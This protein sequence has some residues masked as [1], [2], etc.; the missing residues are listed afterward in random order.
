[1]AEQVQI[2]GVVRKVFFSSDDFC[3]GV[4]V[5]HESFREI[6]FRGPCPVK[7][8]E[9]VILRG[10]WVDDP[11]FGRQLAADEFEMDMAMDPAALQQW[12]RVS[13]SAAGIGESRARKI[14]QRFGS[15]FEKVLTTAPERFT[16]ECGV[17]AA[18]VEALRDEW[19]Q[20]GAT[21]RAVIALG[22][23]GVKPGRAAR[24]V[25]AHGV[26]VVSI[27]RE[28]PYWLI[29]RVRGF[30]FLT[31]DEI[32]M[33]SGMA[34]THPGRLTACINSILEDSENDGN[35]WISAPVLVL[36]AKAA[37]DK[38]G[39]VPTSDIEAAVL[40]MHGEGAVAMLG[41]RVFLPWTLA[42]EQA[43][44][45]RFTLAGAM[46]TGDAITPDEALGIDA[47]LNE[48][49]AAAVSAALSMRMVV[50]GGGAGVGK[51]FVIKTICEALAARD[52]GQIRLCAP[53]G[54]AAKRM[55]EMTGYKATT[56]HRALEPRRFGPDDDA[57]EGE[58]LDFVFSR[59]TENPFTDDA[60]IVDEVS[61]VDVPLMARL[62]EAIDPAKTSLIM[63][64]DPNQLPSV[65]PGAVLR[66]AIASALCPVV[67]LD[68]VMR[69]A[70][71]LKINV[72]AVLD[73]R[74]AKTSDAAVAPNGYGGDRVPLAPWYVFNNLQEPEDVATVVRK[75][76]DSKFDAYTIEA[77]FED[78]TVGQKPVNPM[79]DV[80]LL[81][82]MH[83]GP[84]GT[85]SLNRILQEIAQRRLGN[86]PPPAPKNE[87]EEPRPLVGDKI[88]WTKNDRKL[89]LMNG[90]TGQVI[91]RRKDGSMVLEIE[92]FEDFIEIP[93]D[94]ATLAKLAYALTVHKSQGSEYP[95]AVVVNTKSHTIM[96]HRGL[97]YTALSRARKCAILLGD[98][99]SI[100]NCARTVSSEHRRTL[101]ITLETSPI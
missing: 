31:T 96:H 30:A 45:Q 57:G 1:M 70:G 85:K 87:D 23:Y 44:E 18:V 40:K 3:A 69:Q 46:S 60:V 68:Q 33:K 61:M 74:V 42:Q 13:K 55:E 63:V 100:T 34:P 56:I 39:S 21:N 75:L 22:K 11:K 59:G 92:G 35:T 37:L 38:R 48:K 77:T 14:V 83:K 97:L 95:V 5:D 2:R 7:L 84:A 99:W 19:E 10:K 81:T 72:S 20:R 54:K 27:V 47:R 80:Q 9:G 94:K 32:A 98:Q 4:I 49:Q 93:K 24:L 67:I 51:T 43:I 64:G 101:A 73:G 89:G 25:G 62:L 8:G 50:I 41:S 66:D 16:E 28:N 6:K 79:W 53:T 76:F 65:G 52:R 91:E 15:D 86:P 29:G 78:G 17:P 58:S 71:E 36:K 88:I 82:P 12:L 90:N 26:S